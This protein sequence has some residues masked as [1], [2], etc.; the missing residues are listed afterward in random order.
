MYSWK[1]EGKRK[2]EE[3]YVQIVSTFCDLNRRYFGHSG[4]CSL[5]VGK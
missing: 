5:I 1:K 3:K 4:A 2:R